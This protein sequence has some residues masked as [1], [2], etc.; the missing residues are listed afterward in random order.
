M[1]EVAVNDAADADV[2]RKASLA[3][4]QRAV[5][6]QGYVDLH[7]GFGRAVQQVDHALVGDVVD[8]H[9]YVGGKT[10]LRIGDLGAYQARQGVAQVVRRH[11]QLVE[12]DRHEWGRDEV[13]HLLDLPGQF[14]TRGEQQHV[15]VAAGVALVEV[16]GAYHRV[17][18]G[19]GLDVGELA[20]DLETLDSVDH[21]DAGVAHLA[22]P[23]DVAL[24]VEA[25]QQLNH[26]RDGLAVVGSRDKRL[27]DLGVLRQAV[28]RYL[29]RLDLGRHGGLPEQLQIGV[30]GMVGHVD[31]AVRGGDD[32]EKPG[33]AAVLPRH[34]GPPGAEH[35]ERPALRVLEVAAAAVGEG[36]EVAVVVIAAAWHH[37]VVGREPELA[38][39]PP[40]QVRGHLAVVHDP[41]GLAGAAR[42]KAL[43]D[44]LHLALVEVVV[45]L[46]LGVA[47]ELEGICLPAVESEADEELVH[48]QAENVVERDHAG[49]A[50]VVVGNAVVPAHTARGY[51]EHGV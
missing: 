50:I 22:A 32:L 33:N 43:L 25:R 26:H 20:V 51:R 21:L 41:Q 7:P 29:Y 12:L 18:A 8:L 6:P 44:L 46:H 49:V 3:G 28:E 37:G 31:E 13:E 40:E 24:F 19:G 10:L 17:A 1:L 23:D 42:R 9:A 14:R 48:H 16:A 15:G 47:R 2:L 36:H 4:D 45:D 34:R 11:E 38:H 27:H 5:A 30:E 35:V 39:D